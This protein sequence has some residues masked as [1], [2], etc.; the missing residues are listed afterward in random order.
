VADG[1]G[2][3]ALTA[4]GQT[5]TNL[6]TS[7]SAADVDLTMDVALDKVPDG[8]G[9]QFNSTVRRTSAGDYHLKLRYPSTG[10]VSASLAKTVG[11]T[12]TLIASANLPGAAVT[13]GQVLRVRFQV[14]G[15]GSTVLKAKIW[16]AT[17]PEPAAW[18]LSSTHSE[19]LLQA[20]GQVGLSGYLT[21]TATT[22]PLTMSV[23]NIK[24]LVP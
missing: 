17:D 1:A 10:V 19:P 21:S 2:K 6:L 12:E 22:V 9:A 3:L 14:V 18:L 5:R 23:D 4:K 8:G 11:T 13:A 20:A 24:A 15:S 16:R 7:V